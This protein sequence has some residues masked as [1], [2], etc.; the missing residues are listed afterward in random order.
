MPSSSNSITLQPPAARA[1]QLLHE[2]GY[3][4]YAVG[5]CVRDSLMGRPCG[6]WD[7]TTAAAPDEILRVFARFWTI[8]TGIRHGTVTVLIDGTPLE[9]TTFRTESGYADGRHPD[10]VRFAPRVEDDL[11]RRDFTV[12]AM[13]Y[14]PRTGLIDPFHGLVDL[15]E[16]RI[17]C[18]GEPAVR[19]SE[20]GLR[21]LRAVRF[22]AVL[23]FSIED[24]TADA[25]YACADMLKCVSAERKA[26]ELSKL[27]KG[28][29]AAAVVEQ[30]APLLQRIIPVSDSA[31][32]RIGRLPASLLLRLAALLWDEAPETAQEAL[33]ALRYDKKTI[34]TVRTLLEAVHAP[35]PGS[36]GAL[37]RCIGRFGPLWDD[38]LTLVEAN[39]ME[40]EALRRE[41]QA[42]RARGDCVS[43]QELAVDGR[44]LQ[45]MGLQ[46]P[47]IGRTLESLLDDV[48]E[49]RLA[50]EETT[51]LDAAKRY[52]TNKKEV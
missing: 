33:E 18:V 9:I 2:A 49:D 36:L 34:Q 4:A 43:L 20:D 31:A 3:D 46:G 30:Y 41:T 19:F 45:A 22:S 6:D 21:I 5:G 28:A 44:K 7:L 10:A 48:L 17:R 1:L 27:L 39:D 47:E 37:R 15:A 16:K 51:L 32:V 35:L 40:T 38:V 14:S 52:Q 50:N 13:A 24:R 29:H 8:E 12:N 42:I 26:V 23:G 25:L 11:A